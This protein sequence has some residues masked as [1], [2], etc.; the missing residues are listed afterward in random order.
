MGDLYNRIVTSK[1]LGYT[2]AEIN[3]AMTETLDPILK[4]ISQAQDKLIK[5]VKAK[6]ESRK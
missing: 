4:N 6:M 1:N 5:K 3:Q 2:P